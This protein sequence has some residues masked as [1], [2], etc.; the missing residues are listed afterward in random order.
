MKITE[1]KYELRKLN[2]PVSGNKTELLA[3]L[4]TSAKQL[5]DPESHSESKEVVSSN[6]TKNSESST[7]PEFTEVIEPSGL[8]KPALTNEIKSD[9]CLEAE[10]A[11]ELQP[12]VRIHTGRWF[13]CISMTR[14]KGA[15]FA[16]NGSRKSLQVW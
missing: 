15:E 14:A 9:A 8:S 6:T 11:D 3:C 5:S 16:M 4:L 10:T 13:W 1:L 7:K 12:D 2:L